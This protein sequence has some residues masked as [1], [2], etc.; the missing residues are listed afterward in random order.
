MFSDS[1]TGETGQP[2]G[3][4]LVILHGVEVFRSSLVQSCTQAGTG[5]E[6][7]VVSSRQVRRQRSRV[8]RL[9]V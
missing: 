8:D 1:E 9:A 7:L 5:T 2:R 6:W 3:L 4:C